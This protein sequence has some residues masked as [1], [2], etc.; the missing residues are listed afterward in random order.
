M[1]QQPT[2]NTGVDHRLQMTLGLAGNSK[3]GALAFIKEA[4][5]ASKAPIK[6][7]LFYQNICLVHSS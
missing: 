1:R 5:L 3:Y 6:K 4:K 7:S 2:E